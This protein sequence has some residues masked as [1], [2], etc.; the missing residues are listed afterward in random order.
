MVGAAMGLAAKG[1][2]PFASSF[3]CFLSRAYDFVRMAAISSSNIKLAGSH[4]G[5]SIGEDG[6]S[7]M[8]LEDLAMFCAE[9]NFT[10]LYPS[11]AVSAWR[12][13]ELAVEVQGPVYI[14]TT[15][16]KTPVIYRANDDFKI[17]KCKV[18]RQ[19]DDDRV[20]I[21]AAGVTLFEALKAYEHL[22]K[23]GIPVRVIDLFSVQ[24]VDRTGLI[25][26]ARQT[27][28]KILVVEDH[29]IHGGIGDAVAGALADEEG[30]VVSK[31]AV[32]EIPRSGSA[33]EL[34][35]AFGISANHI[36]EKVAQLLRTEQESSK[37]A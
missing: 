18:L 9:P 26:S 2:I 29:Y 25:E 33:P 31:M 10:V 34:M 27:G 15:R 20:T 22:T 37:H 21:V 11:D 14:R 4:A 12:A 8:G 32:R 30:I 7:Q 19:T 13:T 6:P 17:G 36:V 16:P 24:P 23:E 1:K 3:A 5:I 28:G 35:D